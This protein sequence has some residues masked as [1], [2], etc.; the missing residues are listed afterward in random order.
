MRRVAIIDNEGEELTRSR[1][2]RNIVRLRI[3]QGVDAEE[4]QFVEA[5]PDLVAT[6]RT[7]AGIPLR[8]RLDIDPTKIYLYD[9]HGLS[10][11]IHRIPDGHSIPT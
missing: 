6:Q 10:A 4:F 1:L 9:C 11:E 5:H 2:I 3:E 7:F 8:E